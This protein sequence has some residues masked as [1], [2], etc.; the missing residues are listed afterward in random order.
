MRLGRLHCFTITKLTVPFSIA[1][2]LIFI[3][4]SNLH[5]NEAYL[6]KIESLLNNIKNLSSDFIQNSEGAQATGK[7]YISRPGKMRV[8]YKT[9]PNILITVNGTVL[10][11]K[12]IDLDEVSNLSTNTTPASLLTRKNISFSAKDIKVDNVK[13][14]N[15]EVSVTLYKKNRPEAGKFRLFFDKNVTTFKKMEV[16]DG[17]GGVVTVK[18][19]NISYPDNL[20]SRLFYIK[21]KNLPF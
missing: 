3:T 9:G 11:Y 13:V 7:F 20:P 12:D 21:S 1:I 2:F 8:E 19:L 17:L 6:N 16:I 10:T 14:T 18:L 15:N 5:A 4:H